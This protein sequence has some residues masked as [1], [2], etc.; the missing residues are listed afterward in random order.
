MDALCMLCGNP[1]ATELF[2]IVNGPVKVE[3]LTYCP[4]CGFVAEVEN[5]LPENQGD[6]KHATS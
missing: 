5:L 4:S 3:F 1:V 6:L 2:Y